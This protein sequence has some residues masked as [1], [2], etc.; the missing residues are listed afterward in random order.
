[1][2]CPILCTLTPHYL[3]VCLWFYAPLEIMLGTH[4][5]LA[6]RVVWRVT[7]AETSIYNGHLRGPVTLT[8][9]VERL[10]TYMYYYDQDLSRLEFE[11]STFHMRGER[12]NRLRQHRCK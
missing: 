5:H 8:P 9:V 1:M 10:I 6:V 3:L 11:H 4:S 12:S 7:P 2:L